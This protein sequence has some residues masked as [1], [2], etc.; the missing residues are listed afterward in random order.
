MTNS[1]E[2]HTPPLYL[3]PFPTLRQGSRSREPSVAPVG[4]LLDLTAEDRKLTGKDAEP[5]ASPWCTP[6][7]ASLSIPPALCVFQQ[8]PAAHNGRDD[9]HGEG[10]C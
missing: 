5:C 6:V 2:T 1:M 7:C 10:V 3:S 4:G 8:P 9:L